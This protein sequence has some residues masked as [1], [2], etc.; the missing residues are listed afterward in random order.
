MTDTEIIATARLVVEEQ[1]SWA[2]GYALE[3]AKDALIEGNE[4]ARAEW[5]RVV[6]TIQRI[7]A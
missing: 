3:C 2:T 1:G 6:E 5:M 4:P 7:A